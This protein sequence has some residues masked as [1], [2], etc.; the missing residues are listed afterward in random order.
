MPKKTRTLPSVLGSRLASALSRHGVN[1]PLGTAI[2]IT[3]EAFGYHNAHEFQAA[4]RSGKIGLATPE[5]ASSDNLADHMIMQ[6]MTDPKTGIR[7]AVEPKGCT[8]HII[9]SPSGSLM[10]PKPETGSPTLGITLI[11]NSP[12]DTTDSI[13]ETLEQEP[14][15]PRAIAICDYADI[16]PFIFN[17][18]STLM[19]DDDQQITLAMRL[20]ADNRDD[21]RE[22]MVRAI[23]DE[24]ENIWNRFSNSPDLEDDIQVL[25]A[26]E[27]DTN[28]DAHPHMKEP[29][30]IFSP[31]FQ[32]GEHP[33]TYVVEINTNT[34]EGLN[35]G[36]YDPENPEETEAMRFTLLKKIGFN[37]FEQVERCSYATLIPA[38]APLSRLIAFYTG[39]SYALQNSDGSNIVRICREYTHHAVNMITPDMLSAQT[40]GPDH[41]IDTVEDKTGTDYT[42]ITN[43]K[44]TTKQATISL[45]VRE[46]TAGYTIGY[47]AIP[48]TET[49]SCLNTHTPGDIYALHA[50]AIHLATTMLAEK[51]EI[52]NIL[53]ILAAP[54]SKNL[55]AKYRLPESTL[56]DI[57]DYAYETDPSLAQTNI[58]SHD[59]WESTITQDRDTSGNP[60]TKY[61][62][63]K[64]FYY[65]PDDQPDDEATQKG[66]FTIALDTTGRIADTSTE[67]S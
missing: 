56:Y 45:Y 53:S 31:P 46:A 10:R 50:Q 44:P 13:V 33:E 52:T 26:E 48:K 40:V 32:I 55:L 15:Y 20:I 9:N 21:I 35:G 58:E 64:T 34:E 18:N 28:A 62:M 11:T 25:L 17:D 2:A 47:Y 1:V 65:I 59:G 22:A 37:Q 43:Y 7:F 49:V 24:C 3:A 12:D 63:K 4:A 30:L 41:L 38:T 67:F 54:A 61:Y 19:L 6:V 16:Q 51:Q 60:I 8:G 66:T 29:S 14:S 5:H 42:L 36:D 39:L 23:T 57:A 27:G